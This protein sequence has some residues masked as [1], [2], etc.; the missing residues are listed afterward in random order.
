MSLVLP[1]LFSPT[2]VSFIAKHSLSLSV[3]WRCLLSHWWTI[4]A[5]SCDSLIILIRDLNRK[6]RSAS[7]AIEDDFFFYSTSSK[8]NQLSIRDY[9]SP[10]ICTGF[11]P[12]RFIRQGAKFLSRTVSPVKII[13]K[14]ARNCFSRCNKLLVRPTMNYEAHRSPVSPL[15]LMRLS[16]RENLDILYSSSR[17]SLQ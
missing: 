3:V 5:S 14:R 13:E 7:S 9:H 12:R 8:Q 17:I 2:F 1:T 16:S 15:R 10:L 6:R 11:F 4:V